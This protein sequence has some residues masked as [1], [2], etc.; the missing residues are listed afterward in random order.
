VEHGIV[1]WPGEHAAQVPG[2][3]PAMPSQA[4][5]RPRVRQPG[6]PR[7]SPGERGPASQP[8]HSLRIAL[9]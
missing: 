6:R 4:E 8:L 5:N 1:V 9:Q 2:E 3:H 7:Q